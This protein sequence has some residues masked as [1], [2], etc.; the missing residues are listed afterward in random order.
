MEFGAG[1]SAMTAL[2]GTNRESVVIG[3]PDFWSDLA[4][5][6]F[7]PGPHG[8]DV[9]PALFSAGKC[10]AFDSVDGIRFGAQGVSSCAV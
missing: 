9:L 8:A 1:P 4:L 3:T 2:R 5:D 6:N 10:V 7:G